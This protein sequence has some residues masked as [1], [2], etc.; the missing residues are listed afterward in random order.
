MWDGREKL[1]GAGKLVALLPSEPDT[2]WSPYICVFCRSGA[3]GTIPAPS[4]VSYAWSGRPAH[5][6]EE[7]GGVGMCKSR[8]GSHDYTVIT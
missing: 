2:A 6:S 3:V 5:Q 8:D 7:R 4:S 1:G